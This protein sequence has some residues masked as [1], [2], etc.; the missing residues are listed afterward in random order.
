MLAIINSVALQGLDGVIVQVE[1]DVSNGM[2]AFDLVGL[3]DAAVRES[4]ERVRAA[5][6]NSGF[7]FPVQ[8]ITINL[9]PADIRKEGPVYDLPIAIGILA[10]SGQIDVDNCAEYIFTGELS[11]DGAIRKVNGLLPAAL[12]AHNNNY[13]K[14]IVPAANAAEAAL[15]QQLDVYPAGNLATLMPALEAEQELNPYK[16]DI[17]A[18]LQN[19]APAN[20]DLAD[21]K[22]QLAGKRALEIA[23]AG[24]HNILMLGSPG[25]GKTMLARRVPGIMP[26]LTFDEAIAV[27]KIHSLV[28]L[29][30][31]HQAMVTER[32]FRAP[33]HSASTASIVGGGRIPRPGEVSL[34]HQGVLFLDEI[35]EFKKDT[36]EALRQPL[37]DGIV[38][39]TRVHSSLTYPAQIML[40][41]SANPCP[42]GYFGDK[43]KDCC[44]TPHQI[45]RYLRRLSGPLLDRIDMHIEVS[46]VEF[47]DLE[48]NQPG[49]S[50]AIIK[51]RV[52]QARNIQRQRLQKHQ[53]A[54]SC[55]AHM[56]VALVRKYCIASVE[57]KLLLKTAFKQLQLS[58][59]SH[60]KILKVARTI[61]DLDG[62]E[63]I[64]NLH[65]AEALQ[66]RNN[67]MWEARG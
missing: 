8:R 67:V 42:C 36:L 20:L 23:A 12:V 53:A 33:H 26:D 63:N 2:P 61:A 41:S 51:T 56:P 59:R 14:M 44:C 43:L 22:G 4:K 10:A 54:V 28:G 25:S 3:P 7:K 1:V 38:S 21:V 62:C 47:S 18:L 64:N 31:P 16:V 29:L 40:I 32:P 15:V 37:E 55:N 39:I 13:Q 58:A 60:D 35:L 52:E 27:T 50:S 46:R 17:A 65:M 57:A 19:N 9:A 24:G 66:Y 5:I 48:N 45:Q 30:Q 11:L 34:A 49:E 6:K